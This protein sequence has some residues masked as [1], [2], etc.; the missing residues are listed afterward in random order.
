MLASRAPLQIAEAIL[1]VWQRARPLALRLGI[2]VI[3]AMVVLWL[4]A[5]TVGRGF[6]MNRLYESRTSPRW[7]SLLVLHFLRIL[8]VLALVAAY[9]ACSRATALVLDP[10]N[11]N[12]FLALIV[13]LVLF[14]IAILVWS[15]V[16]WILSLACIFAARE[17]SSTVVS[18][19]QTINLLRSN[20]RQLA[21]IA[22]QNGTARTLIAILF[23]F[24][25]L[26]PLALYRVP[27]LFWTLEFAIL[28]LYC[29]IS[30]ILLLARLSA[31]IEVA[32]PPEISAAVSEN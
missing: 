10:E 32:L 23:T 18:I 12:Y 7:S 4:S 25:A 16:H 22:A 20:G 1:E 14:G 26:F 27:V 2:I 29:A 8:S 24:L 15:F 6:V 13:F 31:Y 5:A 28:L 9:V 30:D 19:R 11:P 21:S 3:P 17:R